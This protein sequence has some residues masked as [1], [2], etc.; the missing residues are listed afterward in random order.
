MHNTNRITT[1]L[2]LIL[3]VAS[4]AGASKVGA[5]ELLP[6]TAT[7]LAG[8]TLI[9][10][11]AFAKA[12]TAPRE[13][14]AM[15][16]QLDPATELSARPESFVSRSKEYFVD[17]TA[18]DLRRGIALY[19]SAPSALVRLN[20]AIATDSG[21]AEKV[22]IEPLSLVLTDPTGK[23]FG[24]GSGMDLVVGPDQLKA[25]GAPFAEGTSAFRIR[26]DLGSGTFTVRAEALGA[27]SAS[28]YVLHVLDQQAETELELRTLEATYLHGQTLI[29]E[30]ALVRP[31]G[32]V[33]TRRVEG[34]VTSPAG[35]A[36]PL[37]FRAAGNGV[38]RASLSLDALETP[39]PGL[40]QVH[41]SAQGRA[42]RHAIVRAGRAAFACAVPSARFSGATTSAISDRG[43]TFDL[44][45]EA[46][47]ASRYEARGVL[48]GTATDGSLQPAGV[49]HSAT[50]MEAGAGSLTLSFDTTVV[51]GLTA[52]FELRDLRLVDQVTLGLLHRQARALAIER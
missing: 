35:R 31:A 52:P 18:E 4:T 5:Q 17:V 6:A 1:A 41:A 44:A 47:S 23:S 28:R 32:K 49:A 21:R 20:P 12:A 43:V 33:R 9:A 15:S 48:Y 45:V 8:A 14:V 7:D 46:A 39:A 37:T 22:A 42:G 2:L 3:L 34:Y 24:A 25:A 16:W 11:P 29:V 38:Y 40:W 13:A 19:T 36:W 27:P 26:A 10:A 51:A 50:W 30:A